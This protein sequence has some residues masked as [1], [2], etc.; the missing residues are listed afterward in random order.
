MVKCTREPANVVKQHVKVESVAIES[1]KYY[2]VKIYIKTQKG[3][4]QQIAHIAQPLKSAN[5]DC[6]LR[7]P[8]DW[9]YAFY[10]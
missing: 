8:C 3:D 4:L 10:D 9:L 1:K 7:Q 6:R 2:E 5:Q